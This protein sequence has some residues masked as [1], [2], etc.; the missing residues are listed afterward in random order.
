MAPCP[1][2]ARPRPNLWRDDTLTDVAQLIRR[3]H[4]ASADF[5]APPGA[6]W[7]T[8]GAYPGGGEVI[9]HNDLAPWNTVFVDERPVAFI[10]WDLAA[11]GP[12]LWDVA[13]ALWH[14]IPLY[15]DPASEPFDVTVFE[16]RAR[17]AR[18][19]CDA[20]GLSDR[21]GVIDMVQQRQLVAHTA[22]EQG[23]AAGG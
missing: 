14:F 21:C 17:R 20:Y 23:A 6:N 13:F 2:A 5:T 19:F 3:F 18:L 15:G 22:V 9:C 7:Q 16:P 10:D 11:P 12:R 1:A 8:T 4:D